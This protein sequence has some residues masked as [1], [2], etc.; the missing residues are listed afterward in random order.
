MW[1]PSPI[2]AV[3][4]PTF[5]LFSLPFDIDCEEVLLQQ[6]MK[7]I[8][9]QKIW[10]WNFLFALSSFF[11]KNYVTFILTIPQ[12]YHPDPDPSSKHIWPYIPWCI[13]MRKFIIVPYEI[14]RWSSNSGKNVVASVLNCDIVVRGLNSSRAITFTFGL[15][16][17]GKDIHTLIFPAIG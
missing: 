9:L 5:T 13:T 10:S 8:A 1:L 11:Y 6:Q 12:T 15:M 4:N 16:P 7:L 17:L 2:H 3:L 14:F